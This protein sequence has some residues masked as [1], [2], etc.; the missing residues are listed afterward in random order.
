MNN[1]TRHWC[2][3][4]SGSRDS[5]CRGQ[6]QLFVT[7]YTNIL[8]CDVIGCNE[9]EV[10]NYYLILKFLMHEAV[11]LLTHRYLHI[12]SV[13]WVMNTPKGKCTE[14]NIRH[15]IN[16]STL[17][18][19]TESVIRCNL[20]WISMFL[21]S[22]VCVLILLVFINK[23]LEKSN[24]GGV[25]LQLDCISKQYISWIKWQHFARLRKNYKTL[26]QEDKNV[27]ALKKC[28]S[29]WFSVKSNCCLVCN[30]LLIE[31]RKL[32]G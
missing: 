6:Q 10:M 19:Q 21:C 22:W 29:K 28:N 18:L 2:D 30:Y 7:V 4:R 16:P 8:I 26:D 9:W 32:L 11:G 5:V 24:V 17:R 3:S 20:E 15:K 31:Q 13:T 12:P 25:N 14:N 23:G 1:F 27:H